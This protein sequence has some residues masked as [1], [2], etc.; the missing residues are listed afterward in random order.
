MISSRFEDF[1]I[2]NKDLF[3]KGNVF[4]VA[5]YEFENDKESKNKFVVFLNKNRPD[6]L[7]AII[8][9]PTS[10]TSK[11]KGNA[12]STRS[13]EDIIE[14]KENET[15]IFHKE[16]VLDLKQIHEINCAYFIE[17]YN[18]NQLIHKGKLADKIIDK[19]Y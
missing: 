14:I 5:D 11:Y 6:D 2:K 1:F 8:I 19:I 9:L 17:K 13:R 7:P 10:Q 18:T 4:H 3:V 15:S 12:F 16:T